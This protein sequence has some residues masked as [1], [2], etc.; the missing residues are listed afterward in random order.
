MDSKLK[1]KY[2]KTFLNQK[3][4]AYPAEYV[5]RIFKGDYPKLKLSKKKFLNKKRILVSNYGNSKK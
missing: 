2:N 4:I 3:N 1:K 5:I